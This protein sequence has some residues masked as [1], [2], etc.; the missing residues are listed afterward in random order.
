MKNVIVF[1]S[2]LLIC[3]CQKKE[4]L[5]PQISETIVADVK[6]HSPIYM[7]FE[8]KEMDT[9]IAVNRKNTIISTN[10][11]FNIDKRLP[12]KLVV[13]EIKKLQE[14]KENSE[15]K[16]K[17]AE[18]YFTYMDSE[19]KTLAF[20]PFTET[21]YKLVKPTFGVIVF[22]KSISEIRV[23]GVKVNKEDLQSYLISIESDK[24]NKF[25][26]C[27]SK[28]LLFE[29]YLKATIFLKSLKFQLPILQTSNQ[30]FIY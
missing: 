1:F 8:T 24:P 7:F 10:W 15:H 2:F 12:L 6:D 29:D 3:S 30:E 25:Q 14:K 23:N 26:F 28:E 4:V 16:N 9:L 18:N 19:K 11:L 5:L 27:F 13:P 21:V 20:M 17:A 22:I